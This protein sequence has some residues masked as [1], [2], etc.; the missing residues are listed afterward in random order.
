M[1]I[2]WTQLKS[3]Q[4][5]WHTVMNVVVSSEIFEFSNHII[6]KHLY[7]AHSLFVKASISSKWQFGV[8]DCLETYILVHH[9]T[10]K[11]IML[12]L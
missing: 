10:C 9:S 12:T 6:T 1:Q 5:K 4:N 11:D 2:D 7:M 8:G 3:E